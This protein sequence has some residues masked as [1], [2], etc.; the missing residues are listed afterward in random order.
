ML[1]HQNIT[2]NARQINLIDPHSRM[3]RP[4]DHATDR[5][6]GVLPFFH[7]FANATVLNRTVDNGGEIVMLPR[8]EATAALKAINRTQVT[9]I[10]GVPTMYQALL[11][12]AALASTNFSALRACISGGA[13]LPAELK[14]KFE[15]ASKAVVIEG[16]GLTESSGVISCNP[17]EGTNKLGSIGQPVPG[18]EV[19]LVDKEDP[20]QPAPAGEPGELV[21]KGPQ[22]MIGYWNKPEATADVFVDGWLRTGD[23]ATIDEDG[24]IFIV[25]RLKDMIAVGGFKVF[26]SQIEDILYRHPA[27]KEAL[28]IGIADTYSGERP[29]AY[30]TLNKAAEAADI[31]AWLNP[32][33]GKHERVVAVIV[34]D[35]LPKTM[36]GKLD[37]KALRAEVGAA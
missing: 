17:Y 29:Q 11:D 33:L 30:V 20:S 12:N 13:P 37:R 35:A 10:P 8:F 9:A 36:I 18:T 22:M 3:N 32:Q 16:Y 5:I 2:A 27:V 24:F 6:L 34:R 23:V 21:A 28:V 26:P 14:A 19:R 7:V 15:S 1:S 31:L 25:D 4:D